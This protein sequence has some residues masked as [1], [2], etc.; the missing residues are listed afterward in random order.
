MEENGI[1]C[2]FDAPYRPENNG[3]ENL[4]IIVNNSQK[5][6]RLYAMLNNDEIE[7]KRF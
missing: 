3:I 4:W 6:I 5:K 2:L 7:A 1:G